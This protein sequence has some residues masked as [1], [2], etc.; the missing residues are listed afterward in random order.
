MKLFYLFYSK[1]WRF[2]LVFLIQKVSHG[3]Y[4]LDL[5][6]VS[7]IFLGQFGFEYDNF[8]F[9]MAPGHGSSYS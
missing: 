6:T 3:C 1:F 4:L 9:D 2:Q 7:M 8:S 5:E